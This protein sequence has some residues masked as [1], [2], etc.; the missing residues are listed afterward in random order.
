MCITI[1]QRNGG[2][3][4]CYPVPV[5]KA[6]AGKLLFDG[7]LKCLLIGLADHNHLSID[8]GTLGVTLQL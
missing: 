3:T 7:G 6:G 8:T 1:V 5:L 4:F 2:N